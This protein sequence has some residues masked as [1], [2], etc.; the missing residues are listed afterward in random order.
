MHLSK[1]DTRQVK[2]VDQVEAVRPADPVDIGP[3]TV[4]PPVVLAPMAGITNAA[5]RTLCRRFGAG[6]YVSEMATARGI[7]EDWPRSREISH[8]AAD[9]SPRSIQLYATDPTWAGLAVEKLVTASR[10]DH[11]DLNFGCPIR[12]ITR[13]GGGAALPLRRQLFRNIV[14]AAVGNAGSVPVTVKMR[15][16]VD[17]DLLTYLEAGRIAESEGAAAIALH[18]RTAAQLYAGKADWDRIAELKAAVTTIPVLGNGDIFQAADAL[19]MMQQTGCDG[20]VIGR[21]CL[22]RPW[23][24]KELTDLFEGKRPSAPPTLGNVVDVMAE[25]ARLLVELR[26]ETLAMPEFRKHAGWYATGYAIT[27]EQRQAL[28]R[29]ATLA[30]L[31]A[32]LTT[33]DRSFVI[34]PEALAAPRGKAGKPQKV[35]LPEGFLTDHNDP[36]PLNIES[37]TT[38]SGG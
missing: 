29:V 36:T 9:E 31:E 22:G 10:V 3:I 17:D 23:L 27:P 1:D 37:T 8:F 13:K 14:A 11:I 35:S 4:W 15:L 18:A 26:G 24:F 25:H 16:G 2:A 30:D 32:L 5:F 20:V 19:A 28:C 34:N 7:V 6:L 12:K 33:L 21:G 38:L